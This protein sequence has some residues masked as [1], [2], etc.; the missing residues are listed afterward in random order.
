[1]K[2]S[3]RF[4]GSISLVDSNSNDVQSFQLH[5][6]GLSCHERGIASKYDKNLFFGTLYNS[7]LGIEI[8]M[9]W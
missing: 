7:G 5:V 1:M 9:E 8:V 6:T 4:I 3:L 2:I